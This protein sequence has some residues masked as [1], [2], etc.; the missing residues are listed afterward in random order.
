MTAGDQLRWDVEDGVATVRR[1]ETSSIDV[2]WAG[3]SLID[4]ITFGEWLSEEGPSIPSLEDL[5]VSWNA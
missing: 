5:D 2:Q 4:S 1:V 3:A